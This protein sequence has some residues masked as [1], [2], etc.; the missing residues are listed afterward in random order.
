M[1]SARARATPLL[2]A[3]RELVRVSIGEPADAEHVLC[4]PGRTAAA[5]QL[6][7]ELGILQA[8]QEAE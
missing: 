7:P 1:A 5:T 8:G 3:T 4:A 6:E 2:L